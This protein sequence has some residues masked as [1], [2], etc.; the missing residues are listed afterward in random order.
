MADER[1]IQDVLAEVAEEAEEARDRVTKMYRGKRP[2]ADASQVYSIRIPVSRLDHIRRLAATQAVPPTTMLRSWILDRLDQE[3]EASQGTHPG[4]STSKPADPGFRIRERVFLH[5]TTRTG[6][7][8]RR[9]VECEL[10]Q[11]MRDQNRRMA[12][13]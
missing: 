7:S 8:P 9:I 4:T 3:E 6:K 13:V 10:R 11:S 1:N 12:E 5:Y 2:P